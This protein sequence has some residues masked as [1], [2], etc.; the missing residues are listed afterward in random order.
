MWRYSTKIGLD[1]LFVE[2]GKR[3]NYIIFLLHNDDEK[4]GSERALALLIYIHLVDVI[5]FLAFHLTIKHLEIKQR[6]WLSTTWSVEW[7]KDVRGGWLPFWTE[8]LKVLDALRQL[9]LCMWVKWLPKT[10]AALCRDVCSALCL[11][12]RK[13]P[14][15]IE[16][17]TRA[18]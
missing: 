4:L 16:H 15:L 13:C 10:A 9:V 14:R 1:Q 7:T 3:T 11:C 2:F 5:R 12:H 6:A 18:S 8:L 17:D